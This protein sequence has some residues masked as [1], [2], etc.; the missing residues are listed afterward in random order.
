[1]VAPVL[2]LKDGT[3]MVVVV[4]VVIHSEYVE[5]VST[6]KR[7]S[8][9]FFSGGSFCERGIWR[10]RGGCC[11]D[12]SSL[13][14]SVPCPPGPLTFPVRRYRPDLPFLPIG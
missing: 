14:R 13:G 7:C 10:S 6:M 11:T 4:M 2:S 9:W 8:G 3:D 5:G 1:M 12:P